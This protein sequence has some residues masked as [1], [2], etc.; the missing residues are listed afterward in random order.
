MFTVEQMIELI[1]VEGYHVTF[2]RLHANLAGYYHYGRIYINDRL[3]RSPHLPFIL[4]HE[5]AH[6]RR[7]DTGHQPETVERLC[8][9]EAAWLIIDLEDYKSAECACESVGAIAR[10]LD[11]PYRAIE[12]YQRALVKRGYGYSS[13]P[14]RSPI[15]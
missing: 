1:G 11:M 7:G 13:S 6:A 5:L 9:E 8:D 12:A 2:T 10:F 15:V 14:S 3:E 4:A